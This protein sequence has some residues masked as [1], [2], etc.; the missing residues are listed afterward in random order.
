M[1]AQSSDISCN[2]RKS[3]GDEPASGP[4][5]TLQKQCF[6]G[7]MPKTRLQVSVLNR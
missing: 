4:E 2:I 5:D 1:W 6:T 3:R 7:F